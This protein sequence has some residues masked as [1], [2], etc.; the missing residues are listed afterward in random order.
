MYWKNKWEQGTDEN[1]QKITFLDASVKV[2]KQDTDENMQEDYPSTEQW[3]KRKTKGLLY[4]T[5]VL[6]VADVG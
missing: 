6:Y 4:N 3:Q 2:Q 1:P 5:S